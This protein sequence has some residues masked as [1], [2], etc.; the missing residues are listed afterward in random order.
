MPGPLS[1][2]R[3]A[4]L[5]PEPSIT[6]NVNQSLNI[7]LNFR[8]K[9]TLHFVFFNF[10]TQFRHL[11]RRKVFHPLMGINPGRLKDLLGG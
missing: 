4:L 6:S 11:F 8:T 10:R 3:Q 9:G 1:A 7:P 2:D 5:M